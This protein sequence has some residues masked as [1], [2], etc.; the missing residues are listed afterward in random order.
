M[1]E[2]TYTAAPHAILLAV[3]LLSAAML[4]PSVPAHAAH[5]TAAPHPICQAQLS[6]EIVQGDVKSLNALL[7]GLPKKKGSAV[8]L[9]SPGG[10]FAEGIS[11][12]YYFSGNGIS[13][14]IDRDAAC[15]SACAIAFMFGTDHNKPSRTMHVLAKLGFHAPFLVLEAGAKDQYSS[16]T[17]EAAYQAALVELAALLV[18]SD[19]EFKLRASGIGRS[20]FPTRLVVEMMRVGRDNFFYIDTVEKAM[21]AGVS[22]YGF[23]RISDVPKWAYINKCF[24]SYIEQFGEVPIPLVEPSGNYEEGVDYVIENNGNWK[25]ITGA[26]FLA[27]EAYTSCSVSVGP[28]ELDLAPQHNVSNVDLSVAFV[29][30]LLDP[31]NPQIPFNADDDTDDTPVWYIF[32]P[33]TKLSCLSAE[34]DAECKNKRSKIISMDNCLGPKTGPLDEPRLAVDCPKFIEPHEYVG[35]SDIYLRYSERPVTSEAGLFQELPNVAF[36]YSGE[37]SVTVSSFETCKQRCLEDG[38]CVAFTYFKQQRLCRLMQSATEQLSDRR[39]DSGIKVRP[40][41]R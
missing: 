41:V 10:S 20:V 12:G 9:N 35:S 33:L 40:P 28:Q 36:K 29:K 34:A 27:F 19:V 31:N 1:Q 4:S 39:T 22:L 11:L 37:D 24:H 14:F 30:H 17:V 15:L 26:S 23:E 3:V 18:H 7:E 25:T 8:C 21:M 13:T 2:D 5:I 32:H 38:P 16:R 6:G